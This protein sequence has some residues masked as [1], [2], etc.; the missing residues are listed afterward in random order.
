VDR[1]ARRNRHPVHVSGQ[2][3]VREEDVEVRA[4]AV[5]YEHPSVSRGVE[6]DQNR[7]RLTALD[8]MAAARVLLVGPTRC[9]GTGYYV[10]AEIPQL[11]PDHEW[12]RPLE[13][14][15]ALPRELRDRFIERVA[16]RVGR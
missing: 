7:D 4:R 9:G 11:P 2:R 3:R 12:E 10:A 13:V 14:E 16:G 15:A 1:C 8:R 6:A 5:V